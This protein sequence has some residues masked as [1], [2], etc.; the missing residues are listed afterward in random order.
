MEQV[1]CAEQ[2][3]RGTFVVSLPKLH[4]GSQHLQSRVSDVGGQD[5]GDSTPNS[6]QSACQQTRLPRSREEL[7][8]VDRR[9]QRQGLEIGP[10]LRE[11]GRFLAGD[12]LNE[13]VSLTPPD[14]KLQL[15]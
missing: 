4:T 2:G 11:Q 5:V 12:S 15:E 1:E 6:S 8:H 10:L 14:G 9:L 13:L 7:Q 3:V